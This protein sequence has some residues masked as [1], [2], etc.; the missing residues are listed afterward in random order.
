MAICAISHTQQAATSL[1]R[2]DTP[3]SLL[4]ATLARS[5]QTV[6]RRLLSMAYAPLSATP[7]Q[8]VTLDRTCL[9]RSCL[10]FYNLVLL[11]LSRLRVLYRAVH[12]SRLFKVYR[13]PRPQH[14]EIDP[15]NALGCGNAV[16]Q[17]RCA[18]TTTTPSTAATASSTAAT[19]SSTAS[20]LSTIYTPTTTN[21]NVV[22]L[23][24]TLS[25]TSSNI[26]SPVA[27]SIATT[28]RPTSTSLSS[29]SSLSRS[30]SSAQ[31]TTSTT[32]YVS[33][34]TKTSSVN[35]SSKILGIL[36]AGC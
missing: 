11:M 15:Y 2:L 19:T 26:A 7:T 6:W 14:T 34:S 35:C 12:R 25:N 8:I 18:T 3:A 5:G 1:H 33:S 32:S 29:S 30:T 27:T 16:G 23:V 4:V 9:A 10:F 17:P 24:A 13:A 21:S 31:T 22:S 28:S 20:S 36:P